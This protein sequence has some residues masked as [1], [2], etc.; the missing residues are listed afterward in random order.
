MEKNTHLNIFEKLQ[1]WKGQKEGSIERPW[2]KT[3]HIAFAPR[4]RIRLYQNQTVSDFSTADT[5]RLWSNAFKTFK[6]LR[7]SNLQLSLA[8][9]KLHQSTYKGKWSFFRYARIRKFICHIF[10]PKISCEGCT[11]L[12]QVTREKKKKRNPVR[13]GP[14]CKRSRVLQ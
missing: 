13:T 11:A 12:K 5:T 8:W 6:T 2:R 4:N 3:K 9:T 10:F 14:K 7:G 1:F